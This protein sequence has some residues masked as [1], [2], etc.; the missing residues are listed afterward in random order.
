[1]P[2]G[3]LMRT[4]QERGKLVAGVDM[5]TLRFG[6]R[7]PITQQVKGFDIDM[8]RE[9]ARA[10]FGDAED[11]IA[12]RPISSAQR[13]DVVESKAVHIVADLMSITCARR[14]QV[15][16][17]TVYF[18]AKQRIL[19]PT[20]SPV[21]DLRDL[22]D[23]RVCATRTSTSIDVLRRDAPWV[24]PYPVALRT[25]CL[26]ALQEGTVAA[27]S[28]DDAILFGFQDQDR[29]TRIVEG[30]ALN[31]ERWGMAIHKDHREFVRFVNAVLER[32][33]HRRWREIYVEHLGD[34][35]TPIPRAPVA[36]YRD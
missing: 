17:S 35:R 15:D 2:A 32:V 26:L 3:T 30:P 23:K 10:I 14:E 20:N 25:D 19:V 16:F 12:Y 9:V 24:K 27:I 22:A 1:M 29:H 18:V 8:L 28:T 4:I 7:D 6:Y 13:A 11:R 36:R 33:R 31:T 21:H 34:L 5:N